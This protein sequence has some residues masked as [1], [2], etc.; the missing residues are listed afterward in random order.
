MKHYSM[1]TY[2]TMSSIQADK[3]RPKHVWTLQVSF[4]IWWFYCSSP[5]VVSSIVMMNTCMWWACNIPTVRWC[6][7]IKVNRH[8]AT[9]G[10]VSA[11][12]D[13]CSGYSGYANFVLSSWIST[14]PNGV[15]RA[16]MLHP[17]YKARVILSHP[18]LKM[19]RYKQTRTEA[20]SWLKFAL[21]WSKFP[22]I[23]WHN[24]FDR[25]LIYFNF[26]Q[27]WSV[28]WW[29]LVWPM[30]LGGRGPTTTWSHF[31]VP[32]NGHSRGNTNSQQIK[33]L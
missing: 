31:K 18:S 20:L 16:V 30:K 15:A 24:N 21:R 11:W 28:I 10:Q 7:I 22:V 33:P 4:P 13:V 19:G 17:G 6:L 1:Q 3:S 9:S 2:A 27:S 25:S 32:G 14:H 26:I 8:R 29:Q 12:L 23:A 5:E